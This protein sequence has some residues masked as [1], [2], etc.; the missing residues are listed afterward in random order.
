MNRLYIENIAGITKADFDIKK[1]NAFVGFENAHIL[2]KIIH[3]CKVHDVLTEYVLSKG[4]V[5]STV[6]SFIDCVDTLFT[7]DSKFKYEGKAMDIEFE[8]KQFKMSVKLNANEFSSDSCTPNVSYIPAE[9]SVAAYEHAHMLTD[10]NY[11]HQF[12]DEHLQL[13][14]YYDQYER[15]RILDTDLE[16]YSNARQQ[17]IIDSDKQFELHR[18]SSLLKSL[19]PILAVTQHISNTNADS[20]ICL[21]EPEQSLT[22]ELQT[23]LIDELISYAGSISITTNSQYV[24]YYLNN[25]ILANTISPDDVNIFELQDDKLVRTQKLNGTLAANCLDA[26][27]KTV[28]DEFYNNLNK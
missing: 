25:K 5:R 24:L 13:Q 10:D 12:I 26:Q 11:L 14:F 8:N 18:M 20:V 1:F 4:G 16:Y 9:R 19:V 21:E 6:A 2:L 7:D 27:M 23:K 17:Y 28:M 22:P 3:F 15:I